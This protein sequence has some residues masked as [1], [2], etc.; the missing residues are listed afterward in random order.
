MLGTSGQE[1]ACLKIF[2]KNCLVGA[3]VLSYFY[4]ETWALS[5]PLAS[6]KLPWGYHET[7]LLRGNTLVN[8][9]KFIKIILFLSIMVCLTIMVC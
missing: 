8:K 1:E 3:R 9:R 5:E 7:A 2:L 6:V 4:E